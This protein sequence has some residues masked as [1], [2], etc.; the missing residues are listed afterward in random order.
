MASNSW[1]LHHDNALILR[2]FFTKNSTHVAPQPLYSPDLA[3]CDFWLF[4]K[5]KRPLRGN[6]FE[7]IEE[8][9]HETVRA[10]K[11]IPTDDF[12]ACFEDWRKLWHKCIGV[13]RDYFEGAKN[14]KRFFIL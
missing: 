3:L 11:A 4:P 7:S 13:G 12:L 9:E 14:K 2:E 1:I 6:R 5:L 8:I 10:L